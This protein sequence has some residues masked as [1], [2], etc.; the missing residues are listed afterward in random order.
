MET[1]EIK[2][3]ICELAVPK[4]SIKWLVM[5]FGVPILFALVGMFRFYVAAPLTYADKMGTAA[6]ISSIREEQRLNTER[7]NFLLG[8]LNSLN[9]SMGKIQ[10]Q[11]DNLVKE[12]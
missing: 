9:T 11:L 10:L 12:K 5:I 8:A 7:Y 6:Q 2:N 1:P 4:A 3:L